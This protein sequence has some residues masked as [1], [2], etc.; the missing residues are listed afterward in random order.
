LQKTDDASLLDT[1]H[2]SIDAAVE[3]VLTRY[4]AVTQL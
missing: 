2:L 1:T 4:K 3:A